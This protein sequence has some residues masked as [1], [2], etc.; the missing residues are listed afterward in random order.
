M[1]LRSR[2]SSRSSRRCTG[3]SS[4]GPRAAA[5]GAAS[6]AAGPAWAAGRRPASRAP[7]AITPLRIWCRSSRKPIA[8]AA[9][10]SASMS[11]SHCAQA[12]ASAA[13]SARTASPP[14][15]QPAHSGVLSAQPYTSVLPG[16]PMAVA[17][18]SGSGLTIETAAC[19]LRRREGASARRS[20]V[21]N[22]VCAVATSTRS[23]AVNPM[24]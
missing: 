4:V 18:R 24:A 13:A 21:S 1:K 14:G 23:G 20:P 22:S 9:A 19:R 7:T 10:T 16:R 8:V 12:V 17:T 3:D 5:G 2:P 11:A 6:A 15:S